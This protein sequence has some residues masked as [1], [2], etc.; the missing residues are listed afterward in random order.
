MPSPNGSAAII[1][2]N[3]LVNLMYSV[4]RFEFKTEM[5]LLVGGKFQ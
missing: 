2:V 1:S 5:K 3:S 4:C